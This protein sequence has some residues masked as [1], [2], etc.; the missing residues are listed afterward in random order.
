[1][2]IVPAVDGGA[3]VVLNGETIKVS[4]DNVPQALRTLLETIAQLEERVRKLEKTK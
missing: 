3:S 4:P 1:M 2:L